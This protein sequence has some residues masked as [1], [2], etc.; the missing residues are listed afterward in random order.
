MFVEILKSLFITLLTAVNLIANSCMIGVLVRNQEIQEDVS[1]PLLLALNVSDLIHSACFGMISLTLSWMGQT[2]DTIPYIIKQVQFFSMRFTRICS[3]NLVAATAVVKLITI[4]KPLRAAQLITKFRIRV[5]L[6]ITIIIPFPV[7]VLAILKP[8]NYS[9]VSKE[10]ST[11]N[12]NKDLRP[13]IN[14]MFVNAVAILC[15]SY[16]YIFICVVKQLINTRRLVVPTSVET[17]QP[18]PNP[19]ITAL[20]T[21]KGIVAVLTVYT[22]IYTPALFLANTYKHLEVY[23]VFYWLAYSLGFLNVFAYVAFSKAAR[24][25]LK[26]FF[27]YITRIN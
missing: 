8:L 15:L 7:C 3:L 21:S 2:D 11:D 16:F 13:V 22:V 12:N 19:V 27:D 14:M 5:I 9:Y 10:T 17:E 26:R 20:K 25:E 24:K 4:V 6:I 23:F 18:A 1:T